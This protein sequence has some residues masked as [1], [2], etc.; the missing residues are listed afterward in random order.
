MDLWEIRA[1]I[2]TE[3]AEA[4]E[5]ALLEAEATGWT[6]LEDAIERRAWVVGVFEGKSEAEAAWE[7]LGPRLPAASGGRPAPRRLPDTDWALSY[8]AHFQAWAF[9]RLHW[10]PIWERETFR[11]PDGHLVL[12][13]D[14]GLA[15]GTGNHETTRLCIERMVALETRLGAAVGSVR[16]VDAGCGSGILALSAVLLG[17]GQVVAFDNDPEAVRISRENAEVNGLAE[18]VHFRVADLGSGFDRERA[19]LVLANIQADVLARNAR[20]LAVAVAPEGILELSG[21]LAAEAP[22][23]RQAFAAVTPGWAV[24]SRVS[25][26]WCDLCLARPAER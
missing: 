5:L 18:R 24:D 25:G 2:P 21:I 16:V 7:S 1:E 11:C 9:G 17:F 22:A 3:A 23:I 19:G 6:I 15:F 10:V 8:R 26:E 20:T 12:W 13:L 4:A 14:P